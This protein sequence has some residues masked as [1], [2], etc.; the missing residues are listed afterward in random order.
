MKK[1]FNPTRIGLEWVKDAFASTQ[2]E[3][4]YNHEK[5]DSIVRIINLDGILMINR[6]PFE[7]SDFS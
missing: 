2:V 3:P 1:G 6:S 5:I 7:R 4:V